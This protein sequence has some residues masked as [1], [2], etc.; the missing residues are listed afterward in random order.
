MLMMI[1]LIAM[2]ASA[3]INGAIQTTDVTGTIVNYNVNPP[4]QFDAVYLTGRHQNTNDFQLTPGTYFFQVT[5]PSGKVILDRCG[6]KS[7][8]DRDRRRRQGNNHRL[9]RY[10]PGRFY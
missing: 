10:S 9:N 8:V 3:A 7:P 5:D 6:H 2:P 1:S 4:S